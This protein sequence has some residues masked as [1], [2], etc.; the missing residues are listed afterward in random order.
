MF[1]NS[2]DLEKRHQRFISEVV[3]SNEVW[4]LKSEQ[5]YVSSSSNH[6]D[7]EEEEPL[8]LQIFWSTS[9]EAGVC[10]R[11]VWKQ[12]NFELESISLSEFIEF[13]CV[14]M[15]NDFVIVGTNFD[16][17][18]FGSER[19]PLILAEELLNHLKS[20]GSS[21]EF[22]NYESIDQFLNSIKEHT[23]SS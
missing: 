1:K 5:G 19:E 23:E 22:E 16:H 21:I 17:Q 7:D 12:E 8:L 14:G 4:T 15:H 20:E 11:N 13:W 2:A 6:Y 3:S 10:S 18:L 9:K